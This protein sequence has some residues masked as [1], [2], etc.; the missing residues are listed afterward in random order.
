MKKDRHIAN[1]I[2]NPPSGKLDAK[3]LENYKCHWVIKE[4]DGWKPCVRSAATLI[5]VGNKAI[6][7]GGYNK[8]ALQDL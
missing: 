6:M 1:E 8:V 5:N 4:N 7:F 2:G 3:V